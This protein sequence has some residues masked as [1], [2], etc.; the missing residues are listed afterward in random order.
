MEIFPAKCIQSRAKKKKTGLKAGKNTNLLQL[1][2]HSGPVNPGPCQKTLLFAALPWKAISPHAPLCLSISAPTGSHFMS[3]GDKEKGAERGERGR[4][5][6]KAN[7]SFT[8]HLAPLPLLHQAERW[9]TRL[10]R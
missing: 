8:Q 1:Q 5:A 2:S 9:R 3:S 6:P 10:S 7:H 4:D